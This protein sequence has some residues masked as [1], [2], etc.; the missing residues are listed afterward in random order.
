M[1]FM[2]DT[3]IVSDLVRNPQ[4]AVAQ[5]ISEVGE[6]DVCTSI[7]VAAEIRFGAFKR[8]SSRLT[9]QV[10][11][12]LSGLSIIPFEAPADEVY[13]RLRNNLEKKGQPI[14]GNDLLI[15]AHAIALN[16]RLVSANGREFSRI[17]ELTCENWLSR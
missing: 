3:N 2:L 8:N 11:T 7:I 4:G 9:L 12:V 16:C 5:R 17:E 15:A 13:A 1:R 10:N 6:M 14:S